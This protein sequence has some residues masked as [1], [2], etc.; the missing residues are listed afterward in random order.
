LKCSP[1][2]SSNLPEERPSTKLDAPSTDHKTLFAKSK[3]ASI[4][5]VSQNKINY[6]HLD[7]NSAA[8]RTGCHLRLT[9]A[10][11]NL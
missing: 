6:L 10:T 11:L 7:K 3:L 2:A 4:Y 1:H 5:I 8:N 9:A